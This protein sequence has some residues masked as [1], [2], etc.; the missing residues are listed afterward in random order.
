LTQEFLVLAA[1][2][3]GN[4][5]SIMATEITTAPVAALVVGALM[6][7]RLGAIDDLVSPDDAVDI[8][9]HKRDN[10][11]FVL[12]ETPDTTH[13]TAIKMRKPEEDQRK[14]LEDALG[15]SFAPDAKSL[16]DICRELTLTDQA[17]F[18]LLAKSASDS[19]DDLKKIAIARTHMADTLANA[20]D[21][22]VTD[23]V[24]VIHGIRDKGFWTHRLRAPSNRRPSARSECFTPSPE[25]MAISRYFLS[26]CRGS[27]IGRHVG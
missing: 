1:T 8:V 24:F 14:I 17:R 4:G 26:W 2:I 10:A 7:W 11:S 12:I 6:L 27:A 23:V 22:K 5:E 15:G 18:L 21:E 20:P 13:H 9:V 3:K 19:H 25:P 16:A